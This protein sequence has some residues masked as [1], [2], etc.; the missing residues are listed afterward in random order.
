MPR[1]VPGA[2]DARHVEAFVEKPDAET[3]ERY[4]G[5]GDYLWNAGMFVVRASVLLELLAATHPQ[6]VAEL[7]HHC[8]A[9]HSALVRASVHG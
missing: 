8:I 3:A 5:S 1:T 6:M 7:L 4:V 2:P 9:L